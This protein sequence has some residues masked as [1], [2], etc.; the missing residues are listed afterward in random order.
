MHFSLTQRAISSH[1]RHSEYWA[2]IC[3]VPPCVT[4]TVAS[5]Q[6]L[7]NPRGHTIIVCSLASQPPVGELAVVGHQQIVASQSE[8]Y[9][10]LQIFLCLNQPH[11]R[12]FF[13]FI[14]RFNFFYILKS[15]DLQYF[16]L[17][18][19][20]IARVIQSLCRQLSD[21][22]LSAGTTT[23]TSFSGWAARIISAM[24][25]VVEKGESF[26]ITK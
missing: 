1:S 26:S 5:S 11:C 25:V 17:V 8:I 18:A 9:H 6:A 10:H 23:A 12:L 19:I 20:T 14:P 13:A 22:I 15:F 2:R 21:K 24:T 3:T 4:V 16:K 7:E